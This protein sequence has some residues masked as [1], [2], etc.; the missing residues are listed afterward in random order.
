MPLLTYNYP[1]EG[2]WGLDLGLITRSIMT[3]EFPVANPIKHGRNYSLDDYTTLP[4]N[5][6]ATHSIR[7]FTLGYF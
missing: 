2:I 7:E 3:D 6:G 4:G 5:S 1:S